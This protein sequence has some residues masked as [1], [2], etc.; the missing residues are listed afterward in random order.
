MEGGG[1]VTLK[2]WQWVCERSGVWWVGVRFNKAKI[3]AVD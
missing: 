2:E 1:H 3:L